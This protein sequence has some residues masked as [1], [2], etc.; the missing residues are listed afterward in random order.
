MV[1]V[2]S[3]KKWFHYWKYDSF[4]LGTGTWFSSYQCLKFSRV[5]LHEDS[6]QKPIAC[7]RVISLMTIIINELFISWVKCL[8]HDEII[9]LWLRLKSISLMSFFERT[10][11]IYIDLCW[12][13]LF[14]IF[15]NFIFE[16]YFWCFSWI[17]QKKF[18][19]S[20]SWKIFDPINLSHRILV[21]L[22]WINFDIASEMCWNQTKLVG[23][24]TRKEKNE[25]I[26]F[27]N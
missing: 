6:K 15:V 1:T 19:F 25:N 14:L 10:N 22:K 23:T 16:T 2:N 21:L 20:F 18:E 5:H 7:F 26:L 8:F 12:H 11:L 17:L 3:N 4:R 13:L 9:W 27:S 24:E